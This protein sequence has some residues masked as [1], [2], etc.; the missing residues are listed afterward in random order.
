MPSAAAVAL[1]QELI[2]ELTDAA[3]VVIGAPMYNFAMPSTL[4]AWV[5]HVHVLGGTA[6][7]DRTLQPLLGKPV[8]V[9][10][11]RVTPGGRDQ[12][13]DFILGPLQVILGESMGMDVTGFVVHTGAA[14]P[15]DDFHRPVDDV[16]EEL[17][18]WAAGL[19]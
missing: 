3:A 18:A 13:S 1:Q 7:A 15:P 14:K 19:A 11:P 10:S 12:R 4:K 16:R 6:S 2:G 17:V 9:V 8:V 5:D